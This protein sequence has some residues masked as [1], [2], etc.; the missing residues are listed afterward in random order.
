MLRPDYP[1]FTERLLLRPFAAE[2]LEA[3]LGIHG[4][5]GVARY[6]YWEARDRA[7][8][9]DVL[10]DKVR[11]TALA[12][13]GDVLS[14]AAVRADTRELVGDVS[15]VWVSERHRQGEVGYLLHPA[16]RGRGYATEAVRALLRLGFEELGLHRIVGRLDGRNVG[17]ARVLERLGMRREAQLVENELVKGQWTDEL[18]YALLDREWAAQAAKPASRSRACGGSASKRS[19]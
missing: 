16:Q 14:L 6:L 1:I 7:Q 10:A 8:V 11:M 5:P 15:L 13:E 2:D 17:S 12:H 4:D 9:S 19:A 3:L 18:V